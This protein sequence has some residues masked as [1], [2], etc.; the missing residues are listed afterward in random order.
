MKFWQPVEIKDKTY[1]SSRIGL[2]RISLV[3]ELNELKI[4]ESFIPEEEKMKEDWEGI[5]KPLKLDEVQDSTAWKRWFVSETDRTIK[6]SPILPNRPV[7][8]RPESQIQILP[9]NKALFYVSIP[10]S[11]RISIS[12]EK[13]LTEI[14]TQILSNTWFGE[15]FE[16]E[17][18]YAVKSQAISNLKERKVK[19]YTAIC[20]ISI[21]NQSARN[22][23]FQRL[24]I[25][26][27]FLGVYE[28]AKHLWTNQIDVKLEGDEQRSVIDISETAPPLEEI[29]GQLSLSRVVPTKKLYRR[30]FSDFPFIKG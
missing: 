28:G 29:K 22:F 6:F 2:L 25:H 12:D 1:Y 19:A 20:P 9:G 3:K 21:E 16:G 14:P 13:V 11:L 15:P 8:V 18:C 27:E 17:L 24:S 26:T 30:M 5:I 10:V 4:S 7:V 23:V